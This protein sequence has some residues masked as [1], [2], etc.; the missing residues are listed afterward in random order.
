MKIRFFLTYLLALIF[1]SLLFAGCTSPEARNTSSTTDHVTP[2]RTTY[3]SI[4]IGTFDPGV[5]T[6]APTPDI[7]YNPLFVIINPVNMWYYSGETF[8]L[9]GNTNL[10]PDDK[11]R[12]EVF[13]GIHPTPYGYQYTTA[14]LDRDVKIQPGISG[15]KTWSVSVNLTD[16]PSRC[17]WVWS[18]TNYRSVRNTTSFYVCDRSYNKTMCE[19]SHSY[20]DRYRE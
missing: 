5:W 16:Y 12:I 2:V 7:H 13:E 10:Q 6:T 4:P 1:I 8:E 11:L 18:S 3:P 15:A 17:Y 14:G 19:N 20:C 9:N